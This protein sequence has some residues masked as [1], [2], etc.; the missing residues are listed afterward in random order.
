MPSISYKSLD[1]YLAENLNAGAGQ[2]KELSIPN[3]AL[4]FGEALLCRN[5]LET[6]V[7]TIIPAPHREFNYQPLDGNDEGIIDGLERVATYSLSPGPK[8]VVL[9]DA[10]VFT[11]SQ[12]MPD[13][14]QKSFQ[15]YQ[16]NELRQASK[17]LIAYLGLKGISIEDA[18]DEK[19]RLELTLPETVQTFEWVDHLLQYVRDH[20]LKVPASPGNTR[21]ILK[22]AILRGFPSQ[23][24]LIITTD[25]VD[26]RQ[27]LFKTID[28][29]GIVVD[30][31][32]P[33][34]ERRADR[35]IQEEILQDK[36]HE[37]LNKAGKNMEPAVFQLLVQMTGFDLSI[38]CQNLEKLIDYV[39]QRNSVHQ[40]DVAAVLQRTKKDP[41][42]EL[43]NAV[44]DRRTDDALIFLRSLLAEN[45]HP[46]QVLAALVNQF[47]KLL[48]A[49]DF[50]VQTMG[51]NWY[52]NISFYAFKADIL[53]QMLES[54]RSLLELK[55]KWQ[56]EEV[57]TGISSR[58][59]TQ[60]RKKGKK[61]K[62]DLV[63]VKSA[64]NPYPAYQ[65]FQ[66]AGK[67]SQEELWAAYAKLGATD[68]KLKSSGDNPRLIL[69][70]A[71]LY[72]CGSL[73]A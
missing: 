51:E 5:A 39:G 7:K 40:E 3:T 33:K 72:V 54:D 45:Y 60:K 6:L 46:L 69:E 66:K 21:H 50:V 14:V 19:W 24:Y 41:I 35:K 71:I 27:S 52:G 17:S 36:T 68:Q 11:G 20:H 55:H 58:V 49:K 64:N 65:L 73:S 30:C 28:K 13:L 62:T 63:L 18:A 61:P 59:Q 15:Y 16:Q 43:T 23:N 25:T 1:Q 57:K 48:L 22:D 70:E 26:K 29:S 38:F 9:Q 67:F 31:S 10:R 12:N 47:R 37:I 53:P 2:K 42:Y 44:A 8:V 56:T 4:L 34:G 32:V